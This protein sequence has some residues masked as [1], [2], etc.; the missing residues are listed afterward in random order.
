MNNPEQPNNQNNLPPDDLFDWAQKKNLDAQKS[1]N[2][3]KQ[4]TS[5]SSKE[6]DD[7]G[8][9][10]PQ[11]ELLGHDCP[12][13]IGKS[14]EK[15]IIE[16]PSQHILDEKVE[17]KEKVPQTA[18]QITAQLIDEDIES[19]NRLADKAAEEARQ[20]RAWVDYLK[21]KGTPEDYEKIK[22]GEFLE[23][24]DLE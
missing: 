13:C 11:C 4:E 19:S 9:E 21:S 12:R 20:E 22:K 6:K 8:W 23:G 10:C 18:E 15:I 3:D 1:S 16:K 2:N 24:I 5:V 17:T 14:E 7:L